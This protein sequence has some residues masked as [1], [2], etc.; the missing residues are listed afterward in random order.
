MG[1]E[2]DPGWSVYH[3]LRHGDSMRELIAMVWG[4]SDTEQFNAGL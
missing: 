4:N 3:E 2:S 1:E